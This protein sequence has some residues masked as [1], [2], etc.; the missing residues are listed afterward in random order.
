MECAICYDQ[1]TTPYKIFMCDH[2]FHKECIHLWFEHNSQ[3]LCPYCRSQKLLVPL[4]IIDELNKI[5]EKVYI[6]DYIPVDIHFNY[7]IDVSNII[8]KDII[9]TYIYNK[10]NTNYQYVFNDKEYITNKSQLFVCKKNVKNTLIINKY[11]TMIEYNDITTYC[12]RV[13][14]IKGK[15]D[16]SVSFHYNNKN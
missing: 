6:N 13:N 10:D 8:K 9:F 3:Q 15:Y 7:I 16:S 11:D 12:Y 5:T 2:S 4:H 14:L 1:I